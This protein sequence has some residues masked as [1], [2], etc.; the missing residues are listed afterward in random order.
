M[1]AI[2]LH[3]FRFIRDA[4][5][6]EGG[7]RPAVARNAKNEP[8]VSSTNYLVP[9]PRESAEKYARRCEVAWYQNHLAPACVRFAGYLATRPPM[10]DFDGFAVFEQMADDIDGRGNSLGVFMADFIV[11]A[12]ARGS[13][14]LLVDLPAADEPRTVPY[15]RAIP[16]EDVTDFQLGE[17][18]RFDFVEFSGTYETGGKQISVTYHYDR[19]KWEVRKGSGNGE[20]LDASP[21][22]LGEC[23]VIPFTESGAFPCFGS[24]TQIADM[25]RRLFNM[26]SELDELLR[27]QTFSLLTF[28]RPPEDTSFDVSGI[29]ETIST[30]NMLVHAGDTPQFIAPPDGPAEIYLKV[31]AAMEARINDAALTVEAS[32]SQE[33]GLA[34]QMRFQA[35]NSA[36]AHFAAQLE[37]FERRAWALSARHMGI[38]TPPDIEWQRNYALA[39]IAT[40]LEILQQLQA[41]GA[42]DEVV[43]AQMSRVVGLQ[44]A[45]ADIDEMTEMQEAI[46][47]RAHARLNEPADT[48]AN[49]E[50]TENV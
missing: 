37:D 22:G 6:G 2:G 21:H 24:F 18:G 38:S 11:Q 12:K 16:P 25:S 49:E 32:E 17:D 29:A 3:R 7:F 19:E 36:L 48:T 26:Q 5:N 27:S 30:H 50:E 33:S 20:L 4:L 10:R 39:D 47:Q 23:P 35:L 40:E 14:L 43:N 46:E 28:Q 41:S 9:H 42:P 44:F 34:L 45:G 13:M 15:W 8:T 31:I 1:A